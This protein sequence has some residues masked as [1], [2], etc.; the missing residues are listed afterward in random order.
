MITGKN[1]IGDNYS[2]NG[3]TE[4]KTF[5][6]L[7]NEETDFVFTEVTPTEVENACN[8]ANSAFKEFRNK[9]DRE[10]SEF[11]FA[12][13]EEIENLGDE[14]LS[15]YVTESGLSKERAV[16]ERGRTLFQ[17]RSFAD[18]LMDSNWREETIE[19]KNNTVFLRKKLIP[20]GPIVVFGASNFPLAY[21]TAGGD[22]ASA[23]AAGC[24]VIV[25]AHPMH[26]GTGDLV[27]QAILKA[28]K[29]T[30]MPNGVF[31][32]LNSKGYELGI[33]LVD[34]E[35]I[36]AVGFTGSIKGGRA[37]MDIAAARE[38][39][40]PV[41]AEMGSVNPVVITQQALNSKSDYW[42]RQYAQSITLG[43]GQFC[44]SP[45]LIL[46]IDSELLDSFATVLSKE[47]MKIESS[48]ML[49]PA[50]K[51]SF[52]KLKKEV[53]EQEGVQR[54]TTSSSVS[55][56]FAEQTVVMVSGKEALKNKSVQQ[57]IFGPFTVIIKC[58]NEEELI[59]VIDQLDGQLT[60]TIIAEKKEFP[61][62][63]N[64]I[65]ALQQRVG[66]LIFNGVSTGVEVCPAMHHGGPYPASS[67]ARFTAVGLHS[68]RRWLRSIVFQGF[69]E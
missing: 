37:L 27:A 56:N 64:I 40:I 54:L 58:Q 16:G 69:P 11:L 43:T 7:T 21:S 10:R 44:T 65:D 55:N 53:M 23:F 51:E 6:P 4:F 32:N 52:S 38:E 22:T 48:C 2:S 29:R 57:E 63:Q 5:N 31:S 42:A 49:H 18:M 66:R 15:T 1:L 9:S 47:I 67:D 61:Y 13:A 30:N 24:P 62:I 25:K 20:L 35:N 46:G 45:G 34:N 59:A 36:K 3:T 41:F 39:P 50:I 68:V 28:A 33:Q 8:L 19:E 12:I 26:A 14:L 60:G 17:L